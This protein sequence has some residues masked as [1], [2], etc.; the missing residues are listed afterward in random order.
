MYKRLNKC[1]QCNTNMNNQD[2]S[3]LLEGVCN[4]VDTMSAFDDDDLC[5]CGFNT[6]MPIFPEN[7]SLGQSYV[8]YQF[9]DETFKPCVGLKKGTLSPELVSPYVPC[10]SIEEIEFI[11][12]MN[13]IGKEC[14]E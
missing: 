2:I 11:K 6:R 14:N 7:P 10:Q 4:N 8:P 13:K 12:A 9:L 3:D 1:C 5:G